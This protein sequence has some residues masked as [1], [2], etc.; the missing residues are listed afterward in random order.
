MRMQAQVTDVEWALD[1]QFVITTVDKSASESFVRV[2]DAETGTLVHVLKGHTKA[3]YVLEIHPTNPRILLTAGFDG[4][5]MIWD[6]LTGELIKSLVV[7]ENENLVNGQWSPNGEYFVL[8]D[9]NGNMLLYGFASRLM[10]ADAPTEQFFTRDYTPAVRDV[11]GFVIDSQTETAYHL[12]GP[13]TLCDHYM[14][15][16]HYQ[17]KFTPSPTA[18]YLTE[19]QL[20]DF[21]EG[22]KAKFEEE[23]LTICVYH[24]DPNA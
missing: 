3:V 12:L 22:A 14:Q 17:P 6:I 15:P 19:E 9:V 13:S 21:L 1:D 5:I 4:K 2:W 24:P 7:T 18:T 10:Y 16:Y 8:T 20:G 11:E 23:K